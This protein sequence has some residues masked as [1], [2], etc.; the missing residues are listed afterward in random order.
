MPMKNKKKTK[1]EKL[2]DVLLDNNW[3][4]TKELVR[5][6]GHTFSTAKHRL[7]HY[8]YNIISRVHP[9]KQYQWQYKLKDD[10]EGN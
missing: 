9:K 7:I 3:H 2:L 1:L 8:G 10:E 6:V 5:R 4:T